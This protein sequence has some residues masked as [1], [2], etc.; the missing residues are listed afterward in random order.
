MPITPKNQLLLTLFIFTSLFFAQLIGHSFSHSPTGFA[1]TSAVSKLNMTR[2]AAIAIS[3]GG[4]PLPLLGDPSHEHIVESLRHRVPQLLRLGTPEAPRAIVLV[5]AHWSERHPT[6][7]N[8]AKHRLLYDYYGFPPETYKLKYDAPGS[9]EVAQEV[10]EV[11]Q[12]AGLKP[13]TDDERGTTIV[14]MGYRKV[15]SHFG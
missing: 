8:G 7:S 6:V 5:T 14:P 9:P 4:G 13:A 2:A 3:H 1:F 11:L 15:T 10:V 12:A